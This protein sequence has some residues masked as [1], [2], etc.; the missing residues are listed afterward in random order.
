MPRHEQGVYE[1]PSEDLRIFD[2]GED[3]YDEEGSH[4]P[5]LIVTALLIVAAFGFVVW[6]AYNQGVQHGRESSPRLI[7]AEQGPVRTAPINPGGATPYQGLKIYE[8]PAPED[9]NAASAGNAPAAAKPADAAALR[10]AEPEKPKA[11]PARPVAKTEP[12][13]TV[14]KAEPAK[15]VAGKIETARPMKPAG[16]KIETAKPVEAA[17]SGGAYVLQI[18]AYKS[19]ADAKAAWTTYQHRHPLTRGLASDIQKADLGAKGTWYRLRIG[20]FADKAAAGAFC[21][22]LKA[23]NGG[24]F[25]ARF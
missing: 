9:E 18:G 24:C 13:A 7:A 23:D 19:E 3:D 16:E 22:K 14:A 21:D 1:P 17:A 5:L 20:S 4:L 11:E 15:P 12:A 25:P 10:R 2:G 6:F 8:Q